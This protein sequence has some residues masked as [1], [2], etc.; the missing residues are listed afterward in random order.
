MKKSQLKQLIREVIQETKAGHFR[1]KAPFD[2][3]G[4]LEKNWYAFAKKL[5]QGNNELE[6]CIISAYENA[7]CAAG[8]G[9]RADGDCET[10]HFK[11][12][13]DVGDNTYQIWK[14][15]T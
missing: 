14:T 2:K 9:D 7:D 3:F 4:E 5:A 12:E 15:L 8:G 1:K 13:I 6:K 11:V 10:A